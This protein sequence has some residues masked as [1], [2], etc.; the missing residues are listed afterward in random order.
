MTSYIEQGER[1]VKFARGQ[2]VLDVWL[3]R[4]GSKRNLDNAGEAKLFFPVTGGRYHLTGRDCLDQMR[5]LPLFL[6]NRYGALY[7]GLSDLFMY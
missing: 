6:N 2:A 3:E 1:Q 7:L 4:L 5:P